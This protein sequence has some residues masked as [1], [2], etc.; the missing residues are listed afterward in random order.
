M[1]I[2]FSVDFVDRAFAEVDNVAISFLFVQNAEEVSF[3]K[4]NGTMTLK[5]VAP[6]M[7]FFADRP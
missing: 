6:S 2:V 1:I 3:D 4:E 7:T 5:G